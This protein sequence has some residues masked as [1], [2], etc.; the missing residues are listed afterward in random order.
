MELLYQDYYKH[1]LL[2]DVRVKEYKEQKA[3]ASKLLK[4]PS[5]K[6]NEDWY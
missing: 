5:L 1:D 6:N 4:G 3:A 2:Q